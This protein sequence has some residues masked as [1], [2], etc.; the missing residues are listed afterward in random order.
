MERIIVGDAPNVGGKLTVVKEN[1]V[2]S[3]DDR[4]REC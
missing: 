3:E 1:H 4:Y 2:Q